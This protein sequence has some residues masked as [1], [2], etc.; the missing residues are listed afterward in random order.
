MLTIPSAEIRATSEDGNLTVRLIK[1]LSFADE[2]A[3]LSY[4]EDIQTNFSP[5]SFELLYNVQ[6]VVFDQRID[7]DSI[8]K[9]HSALPLFILFAHSLPPTLKAGS[10]FTFVPYSSHAPETLVVRGASSFDG[11][12]REVR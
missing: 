2:I 3:Y 7:C 11:M 8:Y 12:L 6:P 1:K 10:T 5:H 9:V 4:V